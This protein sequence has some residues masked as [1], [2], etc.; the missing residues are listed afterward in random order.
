MNKATKVIKNNSD[1]VV[2]FIFTN[3]N[4]S[5]AQSTFPSLLKPTNITPV[6]KKDSKTSKYHYRPVSILSN[7]SKIHK[8][9]MFKQMSKYFEPFF[10]KFQ[11]GFRKGFS[12]QQCLLSMLQ[13]LSVTD[14]SQL[15]DCPPHDLLIATLN[16]CRFSIDSLRLVQ[17]YLSNRK[18]RTRMNST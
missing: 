18:Q 6:H 1:L 3:L 5:I 14:L 12:V 8:R 16:A 17:N 2:D 7:I 4:D 15:F 10:F 13:K 9:F 11:Y